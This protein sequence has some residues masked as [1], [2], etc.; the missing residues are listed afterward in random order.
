MSKESVKTSKQEAK[1]DMNE[2]FFSVTKRDSTILSGNDTFIRISEYE[3]SEIIGK[4]HNVVR[5]PDMPKFIFKTVW[6]YILSDKPVVG[7]VK[8]RTKSGSYYWVIAAV[9][10]IEDKFL[11]IRIKPST[12]LFESIVDIYA[13]VLKEESVSGVE[14]SGELF[15]A[16]LKKLGFSGYDAF[17][18]E[19]L[20]LEL[21]QR[22]KIL[23]EKETSGSALSAANSK[24]TSLYDV[25]KNLLD[26]YT[27]WFNKVDSFI[28]LKNSLEEKGRTLRVLARDI[29][30]LS[31]NASVASYKLERNGETFG[32]LA[33]DVRKNAKENDVLIENIHDI[34][35]KLSHDLNQIVFLV[36]GMSLQ[37]EMVT[38]FIKELQEHSCSEFHENIDIL[39]KLVEQYS[40]ELISIPH[41]IQGLIL[42][43]I[44]SLEELEQQ[45][46]YLGYI[47]VYGFIE[48]AR[49]VDDKLG[50][51]EIFSQLKGLIGKTSS[52][53]VQMRKMAENFSIDNN[54]LILESK[55][56]ENMLMVFQNETSQL[57]NMEE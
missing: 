30:F 2:L 38:Y 17:M 14:Q 51:V 28:N 55:K 48:S 37:M 21:L 19:A 44:A 57:K 39:Y 52:E 32:V 8:N 43:S 46:M 4:P 33:S 27:K 47:Q 18:R 16:H 45:V 1:F 24:V 53:V 56:I 6:D 50:F 11:S 42:K 29:V 35:S 5:H 26:E 41:Q 15:L 49:L 12:T 3:K 34:S 31:L 20:L 7:Y 23:V 40:C 9:F 25:S 10:P 13:E 22:K 36:S 54:R